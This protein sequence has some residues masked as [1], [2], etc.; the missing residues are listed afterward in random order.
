MPFKHLVTQAPGLAC[1]AWVRS[2][3]PAEDQ[4]GMTVVGLGEQRGGYAP[5]CR[6]G[7]EAG[8]LLRASGGDA[9]EDQACAG[10]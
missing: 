7:Q 4:E 5:S 8:G 2:I 3:V 1:A 6:C 9:R 10:F